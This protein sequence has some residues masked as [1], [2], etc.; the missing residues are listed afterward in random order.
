M[1]GRLHCREIDGWVRFRTPISGRICPAE[2]CRRETAP[3]H[4]IGAG[5][6]QHLSGI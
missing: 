2:L 3:M 1:M 4:A 5:L 6:F